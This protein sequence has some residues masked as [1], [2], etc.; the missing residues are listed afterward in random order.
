MPQLRLGHLY[1]RFLY[2]IRIETKIMAEAKKE[3][4][5]KGKEAAPKSKKKFLLIIVAVVLLLVLLVGGG[6]AAFL[7]M[8]NRD[9]SADDTTADASHGKSDAKKDT[10]KKKKDD[11]PAIFEKLQ[12]FT[13]NLNNS[14]P[15]GTDAVLQTDIVVEVANADTQEK[16]KNVMPKIQS[17]VNQLLR[18]KTAAEIRTVDGTDKLGKE[19]RKVINK[20]LD[21]EGEDDGVL[22]V[23]FTT[24]IVQ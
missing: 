22:S 16:L 17:Q 14:G 23:N 13:V 2:P 7:L 10:K 1:L 9:T 12:Q 15:D 21:V 19:V 6:L 3:P 18:S 4:A 11:H 5:A 24:F 8:G 20:I